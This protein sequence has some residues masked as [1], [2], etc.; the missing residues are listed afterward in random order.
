MN[1]KKIVLIDGNSLLHRAFHALPPLKTKEGLY[2]N[3]VYGFVTMLY[4]ILDDYDPDYICVAFDRKG[5][6]FRHL[7]YKEYKAG[8]KKTPDELGSQFP[9]L[10]EVLDRM[11]IKRL[12]LDSYEADDIIGTVAKHCS[13]KDMDVIAVTGDRDYLQ[14]V[15]NNTKVLITKKG[16]TNL[17]VYDENAMEE[18]YGVNS[19]QFIDLKGLMG[20]KSDNIPGVPG[21]GEKTGIKLLKQF[22]S[23]EGVYE[24]ID[25]VSGKKLP[26]K[27]VENK[28][29][30]FMSRRLA[31]IVTNA[32]I[33]INLDEF[34]R[35]NPDDEKLLEL[36][37]EL[38]FKTFINRIDKEVVE[39]NKEKIEMNIKILKT[40]DE[41][42][43]VMKNIKDG[44]DFIFKFVL[45][46]DNPLND[47]IL[48]LSF[49]FEE[50][51]SYYIVFN[52]ENDVVSK[53]RMLEDIFKNNNIFKS[54]HDIKEE[55]LILFRYNIEISNI[56]FDSVV[57]EYLLE[58]SKKD[59]SL[60]RIASEYLDIDIKDSNDLL[61]KGRNKKTLLDIS[62]KDLS[63]YMCAKLNIIFKVK[64][65]ILDKIK[66]Y[67]MEDLFYNV[68]MPLIEV[69][70]DM[71]YQGFK[72]DLDKLNEL[73]EEFDNKISKLTDEIY[74]LSGEE[75]NINSP[76]QLGNILFEKLE[77]PVIKKTK[78]GYST[79][80]EVLEKLLGKHEI[81]QKILDYRQIVKLKSTYVDGLI[82]LIDKE[83]HKVHSSF[84]QTITATGRISS[85]EPNLQNIPIKT[86]EGRKIRKVFV[87]RNEDY[88]LLDADYSQIELRV[89]AHIS[90]D[91]KLKEAYFENEDIHTKTASEVFH[92]PKND[93]TS[94]MRSRAKAV[95]FGIVYGISDYGLSR[96]LNI[97]RKE[98]K[99]YIDNYLENY[100]EVK[101]YMD[102]I[103]KEGKNKGYVKTLLNRRRFLPE[104]KSRNYNVR[105]FGER[106]AMNTPIQ[107]TAADII[108]IAMLNVYKNLKNKGLKSKLILQVHDELIIETY[109]DEIEEVKDLLKDLMENAID[110]KVP[111]KV[112]MHVGD[113]W[114]ETK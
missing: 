43:S 68:E 109:K 4:K 49:K 110:L 53:L 65:I 42:K 30:A 75:F 47:I 16:I 17:E 105:S 29:Q 40:Q 80:A 11:N 89:L 39:S 88:K 37:K 111:L 102:N 91:P 56:D 61:G 15:D 99:K 103:V 86:E 28:Q 97:T 78:T 98:A 59:Y 55:L 25:K 5:P 57:G 72:V 18:R 3:G 58:A 6:T 74:E 10:K 9:L 21:V 69:L 87:A 19:T 23:I 93:V 51:N 77:L 96:D 35:E 41:L 107:G 79:S 81:I 38:E 52:D 66:E 46:G 48:G 106:T 71:Q 83:T 54:S 34:K 60:K 14:L 62:T 22:G 63:E 20:D 1:K 67:K 33:E 70:A 64:S 76:K 73:G 104:L 92:M 95:N 108:K 7:E 50:E 32:P 100:S 85:T 44:N 31:E 94:L 82:P 8:R 114:Y 12:E 45:D 2:T 112:E 13:D 36:Y 101:K 27:L 90:D 84:N 113:S 24:N 26:E